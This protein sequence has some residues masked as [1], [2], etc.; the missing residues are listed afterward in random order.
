MVGI[1]RK[2]NKKENIRM[3]ININDYIEGFEYYGMTIKPVKGWVDN[4]HTQ[5]GEIV[6]DIQADDYWDGHRGT[7]IFSSLGEVKYINSNEQRPR[8]YYEMLQNNLI[9]KRG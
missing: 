5:N 4:I 8:I 9:K 3:S 7:S 2:L 6:Y 1:F